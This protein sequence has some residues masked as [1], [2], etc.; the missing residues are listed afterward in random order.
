M[1]KN[2]KIYV[3]GHTGLVGSNIVKKLK[4]DGYTNLVIRTH[5]EL[6]LTNQAAVNDFFTVEKPEYVFMAAAKVGG[7]YINSI[8]PADFMF[9]NLAMSTNVIDAAYRA[10]V[11]KL[12]YMGSSCIYPR[13]AEQPMKESALLT[14]EL[15]KTNEGYALAKIIGVKLC[16]YYS[17]QYGVDF[18]SCMPCNAYGPGDSYDLEGSHVIS[19]MIRKF[20]TAKVENQNEVVL[21]GTGTPIREFIYIED[22]AD[23]VVY[24]MN[25][26]SGYETVN[27]GTGT[28]YM[29]KDLAEVIR[30]AI[31]YTGEITY[32]VSKPDGTPRKLVDSGKLFELGWKPSVSFEEGIQRTIEDYIERVYNQGKKI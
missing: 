10:G 15:E 5:E 2:S 18:I 3:A 30:N 19:A 24:M 22:I 23:A 7:V 32:D 20:H 8:E 17:K 29:I 11:K 25:H 28:E 14:G 13:M 27:I 4:E 26:Y 16:E 12:L 21:W 6:D 9:Q 31:G 1:E